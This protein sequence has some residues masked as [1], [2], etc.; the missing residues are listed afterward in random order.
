MSNVFVLGGAQTDFATHW[1]REGKGAFEMMQAAVTDALTSAQVEASA[2]QV[3]HVGNFAGELFSGQGH[4]G[5][6]VA[7]L[8]PAFDGLP[9]S[10]H[11]AAC[12]SGS[13][14]TLAAMTDIE[15]G[16]YDL[17]L[18]VGLEQMRNVPGRAAADH[19][20]A[21]AW[22]GREGQDATFLWPHMFSRLADEYA[23][24]HGLDYGHL[25]TIARQA[26]DNGRRNPMAQTRRW[27]FTDASFTDDDEA[28]PPIEG[29]LRRQDCGQVTDGA[30]A[31]LLASEA[32]AKRWASAH[33][34]GLDA[35]ARIGGWGH[36]T[37][38]MLLEEKLARTRGERYVFPHLRGTLED[39]W[40]RAGVSGV[41]AVDCMEV[42]DCFSITQYMITDH[43]GIAP[44]GRPGEAIEAG[45][46]AHDGDLPINPSGGLIG[47]GH[48][49]GA[50]GVRMLL[51]AQRQVTGSAG[52]TQ[53][54]GARVA[55]TLNI[56]GSCTTTVSFVLTAG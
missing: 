5:G 34:R 47:A 15:S 7:S 28:N 38:S 30:A 26:F 18:V 37:S 32:F 16:R 3:A 2:V 55:Q 12:A 10:R 39:A 13:V 11:E 25:M 50:T 51:D 29:R 19:L 43:L 52:D 20:G 40:R 22:R 6:F 45:V 27:A 8:D 14:A 17:A 44:A 41:D 31:V 35:V 53:V 48:P 4:M 49:V 54:P 36:R 42:H 46:T 21:A 1:S 24:R 23:D 56:G 33:G 9:T